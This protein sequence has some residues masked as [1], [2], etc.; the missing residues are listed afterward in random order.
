[1]EKEQE[2]LKLTYVRWELYPVYKEV[3]IN[4]DELEK[5]EHIKDIDYKL[6]YIEELMNE[7]G[8]KTPFIYTTDD[9]QPKDYFYAGENG[10][11]I[12]PDKF[13]TKHNCKSRYLSH[14]IEID[15]EW[16]ISKDFDILNELKNYEDC[17]NRIEVSTIKQVLR[18]SSINKIIK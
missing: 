9:K 4:K 3:Y 5:I 6:E 1:M 13:Y 12:I 14:I 11:E 17:H 8:D 16:V 10:T 15:D 2:K 18:D 7:N